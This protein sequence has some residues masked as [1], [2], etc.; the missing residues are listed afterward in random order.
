MPRAASSSV[1]TSS[2]PVHSKKQPLPAAY[3]VC[4]QG[5]PGVANSLSSTTAN[6]SA[7]T[8]LSTRSVHGSRAGDAGTNWNRHA[9]RHSMH[10]GTTA[11]ASAPASRP[12]ARP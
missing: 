6:S 7:A 5:R 12:R 3:S 4:P 1:C 9:S 8:A 10:S 11:A 2:R